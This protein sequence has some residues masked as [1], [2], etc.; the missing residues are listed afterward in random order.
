MGLNNQA[1]QIGQPQ[2]YCMQLC[3]DFGPAELIVI[4]S[5]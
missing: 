5:S 2:T 4:R 3:L 1:Q